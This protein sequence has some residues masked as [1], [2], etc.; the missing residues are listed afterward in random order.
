[1]NREPITGSPPI[2]T[3]VDCPSP[4]RVS[5]STASYVRVPDRETTPTPPSEK[6]MAGMMPT[7]AWPGVMTPGQ[8]GPTSFAPTFLT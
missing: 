2:P 4:S 6:I 5:W 1:M 8:F 3:A 7:F